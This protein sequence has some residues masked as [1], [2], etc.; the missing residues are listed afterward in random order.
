MLTNNNTSFEY[1]SS[2]CI[3]YINT[4]HFKL[5]IFIHNNKVNYKT[6]T[7]LIVIE[8]FQKTC[9]M[10]VVRVCEGGARCGF[11]TRGR[12]RLVRITPS[13]TNKTENQT[14][15]EVEKSEEMTHKCE[16]ENKICSEQEKEKEAI[17]EQTKAERENEN[18]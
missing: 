7:H 13:D 16:S 10:S 3:N 17:T 18:E 12:S 6:P 1:Q 9:G 11:S 14:E 5:T 8:I 15:K 2:I 4:I